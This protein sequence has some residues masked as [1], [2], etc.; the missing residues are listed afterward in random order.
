MNTIHA[1]HE[2][3]VIYTIYTIRT[4]LFSLLLH[5]SLQ[6]GFYKTIKHENEVQDPSQ[7]PSNDIYAIF[8]AFLILIITT[9]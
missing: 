4:S 6:R 3:L 5:F 2:V 7:K 9:M 1:V 8:N